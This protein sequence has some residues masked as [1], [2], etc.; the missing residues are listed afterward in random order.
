MLTRFIR[1][2]LVLF[3]ILTV[4][5]ILV[6]GWYSLRIPSLVGIGQYTLKA[7]LPASGGLYPTANVTYPGITIGKVPD[8]EPTDTG[9]V[10]TMSIASHYRIPLNASAN[11]HSVSAV[12]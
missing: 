1:R 4:A 8:V 7:D 3:S 10:A 5:A 9:A 6:L 11:V 2:Q 12:G